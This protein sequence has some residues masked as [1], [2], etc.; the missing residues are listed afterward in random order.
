MLK[1]WYDYCT[2]G[3]SKTNDRRHKAKPGV[4]SYPIKIVSGGN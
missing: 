4:G 3:A 2:R 1:L